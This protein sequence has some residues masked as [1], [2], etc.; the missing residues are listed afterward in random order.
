MTEYTHD[1]HYVP[2]MYLKCFAENDLCYVLNNYGGIK[3]RHITSICY[4]KDLYEFTSEKGDIIHQ[5]LY[6]KELF[7]KLETEYTGYFEELLKVLDNKR[8]LD[9]FMDEENTKLLI[10]WMASMLFRNKVVIDMTKDVGG[11]IGIN[12]TDAEGKNNA[13][14][15]NTSMIEH[16]TEKKFKTHKIVFFENNSDI[17]FVT[18]CFPVL[19]M[20]FENELH[21]WAMPINDKYYVLL[22]D[23]RNDFMKANSIIPMKLPIVDSYNQLMV[24]NEYSKYAISKDKKSFERYKKHVRGKVK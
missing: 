9:S 13:I 8:M 2:K 7:Q 3:Q 16:T 12:W 18:S 15:H 6:E 20:P 17:S 14:L 10:I 5:N 24:C 1:E 23:R 19:I 22:I 4:E 21:R 11:E